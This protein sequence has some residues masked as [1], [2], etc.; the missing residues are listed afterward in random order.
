VLLHKKC[1][2][3]FLRNSEAVFRMQKIITSIFIVTYTECLD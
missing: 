3:V 1:I 2:D